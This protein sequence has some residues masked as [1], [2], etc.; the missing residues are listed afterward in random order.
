MPEQREAVRACATT[1]SPARARADA[2]RSARRAAGPRSASTLRLAGGLPGLEQ[3]SHGLD[4]PLPPGPRPRPSAGA[5]TDQIEPLVLE[6]H[7]GG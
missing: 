6:V 3:A 4:P 5:G 2:A 1:D 7:A